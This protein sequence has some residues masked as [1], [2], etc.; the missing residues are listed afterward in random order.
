MAAT[1]FELDQD[2]VEGLCAAIVKQAVV[3]YEKVI[4]KM[5]MEGSI[6]GTEKQKRAY[7]ARLYQELMDLREFFASGWFEMIS[8]LDGQDVQKRVEENVRKELRK[9]Y[10][11]AKKRRDRAEKKLNPAGIT[12]AVG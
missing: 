6:S 8:N 3:D 10:L 9:K 1:A 12:D 5:A 2:G 7:K 4:K 11:D